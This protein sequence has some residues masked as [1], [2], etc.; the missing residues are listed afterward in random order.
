MTAADL[1]VGSI[2]ATMRDVFIRVT[3]HDSAGWQ[4]ACSNGGQYGHQSWLI[5]AWITDG[6]AK[7][8]RVGTGG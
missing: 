4:G 3:N 8:L 7:V 1:P 5:D 6:R 2:V